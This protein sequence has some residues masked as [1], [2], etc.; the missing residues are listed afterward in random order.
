MADWW[1]NRPWRMIQTNLREIDMRDI[2]ADRVVADLRSF[3]ANVLMINAAGI[4]ASYPT[5]LPFHFQSP[6]LT[7]D[8]LQQIIAACHAADIRVIA[9]TDFSK[10]RRPIYEQHPEWAYQSPQGQ[11]V[12][13]NGDVH[14][15]INGGYQQDAMFRILRELLTTHEFDGI[16]FNMGGYQTRDYS[17]RYYGIC[18]CENCR[19]LFRE[20]Y[21][22]ELPAREEPT[23]PAYGPYRQFQA[24]TRR[25]HQRAVYELVTTLRP[26]LCVADHLDQRRGFIR[27]EFNTAL[28]RPL[29]H[30]QYDASELTRW[31]RTNYPEMVASNTT[32]DFID[33]PA[34][35]VAVSPHQQALRL[36]QA[37]AS[38]GSP[39][40]YLIGRLDNHQDR[41]GFEPIRRIFRYHEANGQVYQ[42]LRS[43]AGIAM[44]N[45]PG[46]NTDEYRGW[47]RVLVEQHF[48]FDV[49]HAD[50][51]GEVPWN[52]Y[53]AVIVPDLPSI[54]GELASRLDGFV[55]VGGTLVATGRSSFAEADRQTRSEPALACLGIAQ[56]VGLRRD[57]RSA[58]LK[59]DD[60]AGFGRFDD[61]DLVY[62][63]GLY[64]NAQ[65][66]QA[67]QPRMKLIPPH[68]FGP[69]ERC[70]YTQVTDHPGLVVHPF[71]DGKGVYVP[72][73][74]GALLHRQGHT[75]TSDFMADLL[76][77]VAGLHRIG[78]NILPMVEITLMG[79][80]DGS[81]QV[82]HL[83]NG[84]GHFGNSFFEPATMRD[85]ELRLPLRDRPREARALVGGGEVP[86]AWDDG[87]LSLR[88]P[89]LGL[90]EA[91]ALL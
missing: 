54:T 41:S 17:G 18:H 6:Y 24:Q 42:G 82:L 76:E 11:I 84:S 64:V 3:A 85:I 13:Y 74:P 65:Y 2:R 1:H 27:R 46:A 60:K 40:Y 58:Y 34:R 83:V 71:G 32:V 36:A 30:W 77:G 70:Y 28:D 45:G 59:L 10:I 73:L 88:L 91:I 48:L 20:A 80:A 39:D 53:Q 86:F 7:G 55:R 38:G 21:E 52:G 12:D 15:C 90:F 61:T 68:M 81:V 14:V 37:I 29:P 56:V 4:I 33:F 69:P 35:H 67:A 89:H 25:A 72:W 63:D 43:Q 50:A 47:F 44:L 66:A 75:N 22:M 26:G 79:S 57:M 5:R 49:L 19:R 87:T 78:G 31:A 9:R 23:D 8:S 16:F 62:L 51:A